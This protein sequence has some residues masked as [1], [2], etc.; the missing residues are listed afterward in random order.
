[1]AFTDSPRSGGSVG[2][3]GIITRRVPRLKTDR[4]RGRFVLV[5]FTKLPPDHAG[6]FQ[7]SVY[8]IRLR[9]HP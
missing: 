5:W 8:D 9:G 1:L 6:T 7:V 3:G 4:T 2:A